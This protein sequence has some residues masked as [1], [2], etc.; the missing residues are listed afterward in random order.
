MSRAPHLFALA[1]LSA[2]LIACSGASGSG[3][4]TPPPTTASEPASA[5]APNEASRAKGV[6]I[7]TIATHDAK[8][9][10][11]STGARAGEDRLRF[12]VRNASGAIVADGI[13]EDALR[14]QDP[15]LHAIVTSAVASGGNAS[16]TTTPKPYVDAQLDRPNRFHSLSHP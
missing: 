4:D 3:S 15:T 9:T 7:A 5:P 12:V 10:I 6:P 13:T 16:N 2:G 8:V 1:L 11:L 14:A